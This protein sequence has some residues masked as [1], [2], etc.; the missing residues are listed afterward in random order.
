MKQ[1]KREINTLENK[2]EE[3]SLHIQQLEEKLSEDKMKLFYKDIFVRH[4]E[5]NISSKDLNDKLSLLNLKEKDLIKDNLAI[6]YYGEV[7]KK[8]FIKDQTK[9]ILRS[10][11]TECNYFFSNLT[12]KNYESYH[13]KIIKSFET[14]NKIYKVDEIEITTDYL[15]IKL[16]KLNL[17]NEKAIKIEQEK[18]IQREIKEQMKEEARA[19]RELEQERKKIEKEEKQFNKEIKS[20]IHRLE[21]TQNDIE[22]ELYIEKVKQLEEKLA[23]LE[24][25]KKD[26]HNRQANTRAGYVYVISNIGSFGDGIYKIGMT[27]RLEP[28]DRV[29]ELGD[30]S[31]PFEFDVHAMIFSED[32]PKLENTLHRHFKGKEVNKVNYRKEFYRVSLDEVEEVVKTNHNNTVEFTKIP[33]ATQYWETQNIISKNEEEIDSLN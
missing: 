20:L 24:D 21:K 15:K 28:Y 32:A 26:V 18:E 8:S 13:K 4:Y 23:S 5:D 16:E 33:L 6:N 10:F 1:K 27:R 17:I 12:A 9:Q 25:D 19:E 14:L 29:K 2:K 22:K 11:D 7:A 3:L 30:A 31:V